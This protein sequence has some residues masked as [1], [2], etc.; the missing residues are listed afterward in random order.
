MAT[1]LGSTL[2]LLPWSCNLSSVQQR[3]SGVGMASIDTLAADKATSEQVCLSPASAARPPSR[4]VRIRQEQLSEGLEQC[5]PVELCAMM[6][7]FHSVLSLQLSSHM[8]M[9]EHLKCSK[10]S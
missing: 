5:C 9:L 2:Y 4:A 1:P 6:E 7:V 10:C 3:G 8:W